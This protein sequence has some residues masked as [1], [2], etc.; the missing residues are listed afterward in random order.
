M[1]IGTSNTFPFLST[2]ESCSKSS[3]RTRVY[4]PGT[5]ASISVSSEN[6]PVLLVAKYPCHCLTSLGS[7][8]FH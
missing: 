1:V 2:I 3:Y 7:R 5:S 6:P 8:K 4:S